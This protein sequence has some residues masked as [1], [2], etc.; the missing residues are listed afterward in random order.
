MNK[1][2]IIKLLSSYNKNNFLFKNLFVEPLT[3]THFVTK[4]HA[5]DKKCNLKGAFIIQYETFINS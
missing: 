4:I 5:I 2:I 1:V 3:E